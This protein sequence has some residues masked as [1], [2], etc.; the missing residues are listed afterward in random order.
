GNVWMLLGTTHYDYD[1]NTQESCFQNALESYDRSRALKPN[2]KVMLIGRARALAQLAN[3]YLHEDRYEDLAG[4]ASDVAAACECAITAG[5]P[6]YLLVAAHAN[7]LVLQA[8]LG[9]S[10]PT[11]ARQYFERALSVLD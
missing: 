8:M 11:I 2:A 4:S 3:I 10:E 1:P 6:E 9:R 7:A 5:P